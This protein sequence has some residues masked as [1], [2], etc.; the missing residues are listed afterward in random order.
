MSLGEFQGL[1]G[2]EPAVS[3]RVVVKPN[4]CSHQ[5]SLPVFAG[6]RP[7][8]LQVP[9]AVSAGSIGR[10]RACR[11]RNFRDRCG[12]LHGPI[13]ASLV[14]IQS[15]RGTTQ[16]EPND[17]SD[18]ARAATQPS[19]CKSRLR[20]VS[21]SRMSSLEWRS[22]RTEPETIREP[23]QSLPTEAEETPG[24]EQEKILGRGLTSFQDSRILA[25]VFRAQHIDDRLGDRSDLC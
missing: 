25:F 17:E 15:P 20:L 24:E 13:L 5:R 11:L 8:S 18:M 22:R 3:N 14:D 19:T 4:R 1:P 9:F 21:G 12:L 6:D 7:R 10:Q 23:G 16:T 2:R